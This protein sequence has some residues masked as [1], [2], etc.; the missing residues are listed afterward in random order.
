MSA[1]LPGSSTLLVGQ[2]RSPLTEPTLSFFRT[3]SLSHQLDVVIKGLH[4]PRRPLMVTDADELLAEKHIKAACRSIEV[5]HDTLSCQLGFDVVVGSVYLDT[6]ISPHYA[7][8]PPPIQGA[9][10]V[11]RIDTLW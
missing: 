10:P 1:S 2:A 3:C 11:I 4:S 6:T 8:I 9:Q 7:R 5:Q